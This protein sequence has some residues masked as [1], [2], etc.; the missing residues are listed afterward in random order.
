MCVLY[1]LIGYGLMALCGIPLYAQQSQF[2][3]PAPVQQALHA[4]TPFVQGQILF[5][6]DDTYRTFC[7]EN[8]IDIAGFSEWI[9]RLE[10]ISLSRNFRLPAYAAKNVSKI[11]FDLDLIYELRFDAAWEMDQVID[12]LSSHFAV[13]YAEPRYIYE[14]FYQPNDPLA[15]TTGGGANQW[16]L[17]QIHANEAWNINK[18]DTSVVI[19]ITDS[20]ISF[21]H[22]DLQKNLAVNQGDPPDGI[23][24]DNDGYID[25][26]RGWDFGGTAGNGFGDNDP[27]FR[28]KHGVSVA[29]ISSATPDNGIGSAGVAF[30]CRYLPVKASPDNVPSAITHG[31]ES[32]LYAAEQGAQV[33]NCSW[34][35]R[36]NSQFAKD[37]IDYVVEIKKAAVVAACGN[38][39]ADLRFYPAAFENVL[40]VTNLHFEDTVC[41]PENLGLGTTYNYSVDV[42]APGWK[43]SGPSNDQS[44]EGFSGTSA[45]SPVAAGVVAITCAHFPDYTG[46][47]AAQRVRVTTDDHY[48]IPF[49][50]QYLHKLGT[51]RVNM[52]RALT[53]PRKPSIRNLTY[54]FV[55]QNGKKSFL[56]GDTLY[57]SGEFINYLDPSTQNLTL[58]LELPNPTQNAFV[59]WLTTENM[60]G[61]IETDQRFEARKGA[62]AFRLLPQIPENLPLD[63]RLVYSDSSLKYIDFEY[64]E[65]L[66]NPTIVDISVNDLRTSMNST[67][68]FG[69][70]DYPTNDIGLGVQYRGNERNALFEG[71]FLLGKGPAQVSANLRDA[72]GIKQADFVSI[73]RAIELENPFLA[74]FEAESIFDDSGSPDPLGV[75]VIQHAYAWTDKDNEDYVI[76]DFVIQNDGPAPLTNLYAGMYANWNISDSTKNATYFNAGFQTVYALDMQAQDPAFYGLSLL[77]DGDLTAYADVIASSNFTDAGYFTALSN[78]NAGKTN[79]GTSGLGANI[80]HMIGTGPFDLPPNA[81]HRVGFAVLAGAGV[82]NMLVNRNLAAKKYRCNVLQEG[83][84]QGFSYSPGTVGINQPVTFSDLNTNTTSW[85]WDF[86][87][88]TTSTAK[89]P[90]HLFQQVGIYTVTMKATEGS[91]EVI[92][93]QQVRVVYGTNSVTADL[94][95]SFSVYPNPHDGTFFVQALQHKPFG[96]SVYDLQGKLLLKER[97][98]LIP[99]GA[100][101]RVDMNGLPAGMYLL[102]L[103][104]GDTQETIK[105]VRR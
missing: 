15:D 67:G 86:G 53:D 27:S 39:P 3:T 78:V 10:P 105:V 81:S 57:L 21:L 89:N 30:N 77:S 49:N 19:G 6:I 11:P 66:A 95:S 5:K 45:A 62:F 83:P 98:I 32:V 36:V 51:G 8:A 74:D 34:G 75:T 70:Q 96:L 12:H 64:V 23:D 52:Y 31:Y 47:Q 7:Q 18:G 92:K 104:S 91:C 80:W 37:V 40:S 17:A 101:Y 71:G 54:E 68:N 14:L 28:S 43:L 100:S 58:A 44:Y 2:I 29:G 93:S 82:N 88:G 20:G 55:N 25:N 102:E 63:L 41:C 22:P 46:F 61:S 56:P 16:Y 26:Y 38:A 33:I 9:E 42:G 84:I 90:S 59:E 60:P 65:L 69:F 97:E 13:V 103:I 79:A 50:Q 73:Q 94:E 76:F 48:D 85:F 1:R 72:N 35:G 24:N 4:Q 87:D 99:P